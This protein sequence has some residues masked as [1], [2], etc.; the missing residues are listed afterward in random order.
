MRDLVFC[1]GT[2][3]VITP[4]SPLYEKV[5]QEWNR[6]IQKYPIVIAYCEEWQDVQEMILWA[7]K[8]EVPIRIRSGG[9]NYEGYSTGDCV[10]VID[11][12]RINEAQINY[13]T[14]TVKV[15]GGITNSQLYN[16]I[17]QQDYPFPG[18]LCPTVGVSGYCLGGGWGYSS[19][20]MGLGCDALVEAELIDYRGQL[21]RLNH[22]CHPELFWAIRGAG[23]GNFGVIVSM[24]FKLPD[25]VEGVTY[26]QLFCPNPSI[27][28]Q[29]EF[30]KIFQSWI[31][32]VV[33]SINM[34]GGLYNT[35]AEGKYIYV[36]GISY[37]TIE[38]TKRLLQNFFAI[39]GFTAEYEYGRFV[40][41]INE[42]A[43]SYP[44]YEKFK[45]T[46]RFAQRYYNDEELRALVDI[47]N[48]ERPQGSILTS[49]SI[50]GLGGKVK[51]MSPWDTAFYYRDA[52]YILGIQSVWEE[53][54]Y[55]EDN[56]QW[57]LENFSTLYKYTEGSYINFP[58]LEL[59]YYEEN[60]YG[61]NVERL[62]KVK[63]RYDPYNIFHFPQSIRAR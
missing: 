52:L 45:S 59:P 56:S 42:M 24:T 34:S 46:G 43:K 57:V 15:G 44:P 28:E 29:V 39:P 5:R 18:G 41:I 14:H 53:N 47:V 13:E 58:L 9:H 33:P 17:S 19:R 11:I 61:G 16:Y 21:L 60:Y 12:S 23:G 40:S 2:E 37:H 20:L 50:Y 54:F 32:Q 55:K 38:D 35:L 27:Q 8:E 49:L 30:M 48:Q 1:K 36:R 10:L 7:R 62:S 3:E 25:K 51:D 22:Q 4:Q 63:R 31:D 6:S 26:F